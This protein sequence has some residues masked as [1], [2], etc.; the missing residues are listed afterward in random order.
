MKY[1]FVDESWEDYLYWL[2]LC[3]IHKVSTLFAKQKV[4]PG[5][6]PVNLA[7]LA[8]NRWT[9]IYGVFIIH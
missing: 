3:K 7:F 8:L 4:V 5:C 9:K 1:I 2:T 6:W